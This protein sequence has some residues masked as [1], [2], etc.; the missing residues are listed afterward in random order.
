MN[1]QITEFHAELESSNEQLITDGILYEHPSRYEFVALTPR[2]NLIP[3][4]V[5]VII[6]LSKLAIIKYPGII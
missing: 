5:L 4:K 3:H 6:F 1:L 2:M